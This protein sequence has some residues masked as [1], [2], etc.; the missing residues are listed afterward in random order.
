MTLQDIEAIIAGSKR[1]RSELPTHRMVGK[2][3]RAQ[4]TLEGLEAGGA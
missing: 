2:K 1:P 4:R 3:D